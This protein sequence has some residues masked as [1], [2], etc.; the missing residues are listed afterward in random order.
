LNFSQIQQQKT[1][2][3][4]FTL[5][6]VLA[7]FVLLSFFLS[8]FIPGLVQIRQAE[9]QA[10]R[11]L[12]AYLLGYGKLQEVLYQAELGVE[13]RFAEPWSYYTWQ[14]EV[15]ENGTLPVQTLTVKWKDFKD[16]HQVQLSRTGRQA[17]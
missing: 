14:W 3:A 15:E 9:L 4:G 2:E 17:H 1:V 7:A 5:F 6:E 10:Q 12:N 11:R 8:W 16:E 13:G